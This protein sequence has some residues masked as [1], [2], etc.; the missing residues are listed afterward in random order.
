[1]SSVLTFFKERFSFSDNIQEKKRTLSQ[2]LFNFCLF[3]LLFVFTYLSYTL[4][5]PLNMAYDTINGMMAKAYGAILAS[6]LAISY[7]I[8]RIRHKT[9]LEINI[10]YIML[11]AFIIKL[12]YML[13]TPGDARQYDTWSTNH[14]GHYDYAKY[15]FDNWSLPNHVFNENDIYQFYH[16]PLH[17]F[18]SAVWMKIYSGIGFDP[19]LVDST[20]SLFC[21]VQILSTFFSFLISYYSVKTLR[22]VC[23]NKLALYV[24]VV[25]VCFFP[26]LFQL[27]GQIN[28]D[29]LSALFVICGIFRL[30]KY[31][32]EDK[33]FKNICLS[34][35]YLGLAMSAKLSAVIV[36]LGFA[37]YFLY[38]L[39]QTIRK[40]EGTP[41]LKILILQYAAFIV[42]CAPIGLWFQLY[43]H[44]VY[45]IPFNFVFRA[46]NSELFT[47]TRNYV[48][49]HSY[50]SVEYY[51]AHNSGLIYTNGFVNFAVRFLL[52]FWPADY[53]ADFVF[54]HAFENYNV[55]TYALKSS[56]FGEFDYWGGE[57][58]G[59]IAVLAAYVSWFMMIGITIYHFVQKRY[60][61][62]MIVALAIMISIITFYLYLQIS[63]P[64]GCSMD[65][66][67]IVP[68]LLPIGIV[69]MKDIEFM[70]SEGKVNQFLK[71]A[72]IISVVTF[73]LTGGLFYCFA[74]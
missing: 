61:L 13:Y 48:L 56:I 60:D 35:L 66:R 72:L 25:F 8:L 7:V 3:F 23:K 37:F 58:F 39:V 27:S 67:Y 63:M 18:L 40:K 70:P 20:E 43:S 51:D 17:Y 9:N 32:F 42:I 33:S 11:F 29:I 59:I 30:F 69:I 65:A 16:P 47:G 44:N 54:A 24:G 31:I 12:T 71:Y 68:I 21:S 14:N 34:A 1:M 57:G 50:L 4:V 22:L 46:L 15:I 73:A 62:P 52:P 6:L 28:N 53:E 45:G 5:K 26:R 49:N 38:L 36:C 74:I 10:L 19:S 2:V 64:Y 41:K 55:L